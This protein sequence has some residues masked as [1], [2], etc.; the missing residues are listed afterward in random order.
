MNENE[1]Q[2]LSLLM[3]QNCV[4][5]VFKVASDEDYAEVADRIYT[6]LSFFL[7]EDEEEAENFMGMVGQNFPKNAL[8]PTLHM[9]MLKAM[10]KFAKNN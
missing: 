10:E 1:L 2:E 7:G 6:F 3:M 4:K 5:E 9:G 8:E